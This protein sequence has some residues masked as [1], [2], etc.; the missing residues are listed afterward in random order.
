MLPERA[1]PEEEEDSA[2]VRPAC[3]IDEL[4]RQYDILEWI[5]SQRT[6]LAESEL[7]AQQKIK[8]LLGDNEIG[9]IGGEPAVSWIKSWPNKFRKKDFARDHPDLLAK[10][11]SKDPDPQRTFRMIPKGEANG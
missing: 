1:V 4:K 5:A 6:Q 11:T 8:D 7:L 9:L 2:P 3:S 10:Y